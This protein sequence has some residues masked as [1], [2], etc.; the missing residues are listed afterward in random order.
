[1]LWTAGLLLALPLAAA[2]LPEAVGPVEAFYGEVKAGRTFEKRLRSGLTFEL[3]PSPGGGFSIWLGDGSRRKE[4]FCAVVTPPFQGPNPL[5]IA[6]FELISEEVARSRSRPGRRR[7]FRCVTS[8]EDF[9]KA[10]W[11]L[12]RVLHPPV[13]QPKV[14]EDEARRLY[15]LYQRTAL[16][17]GLTVHEVRLSNPEGKLPAIEYLRFRVRLR[18]PV[19]AAE[20]VP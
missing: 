7:S 8:R 1:V 13:G 18:Q 16:E 20:D 2:D 11:A 14:A 4:D 10:Q 6:G 19:V 15:E 3:R 17:G 5:D 9:I 12:R